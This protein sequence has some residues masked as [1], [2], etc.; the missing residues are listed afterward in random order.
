MG[1][2]RAALLHRLNDM[3]LITEE[4]ISEYRQNVKYIAKLNGYETRIYEPGRE[5]I[6]LMINI[7]KPEGLWTSPAL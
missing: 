7:K 1:C 3:K 2:S 5:N 4:Y 6:P